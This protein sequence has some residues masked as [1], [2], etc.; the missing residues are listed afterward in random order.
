MIYLPDQYP[1]WHLEQACNTFEVLVPRWNNAARRQARAFSDLMLAVAMFDA[2]ADEDTRNAYLAQV[3]T[4]TGWFPLILD[5]V[6]ARHGAYKPG[7]SN[8]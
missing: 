3:A 2:L 5:A 4:L 7:F 1:H 6:T 8:R